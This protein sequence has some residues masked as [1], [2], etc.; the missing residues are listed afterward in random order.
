MVL[1]KFEGVNLSV[2]PSNSSETTSTI[3]SSF[4]AYFP[5][6]FGHLTLSCLF[7]QGTVS[8]TWKR[9]DIMTEYRMQTEEYECIKINIRY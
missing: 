5:V 1:L 2:S 3:F 9:G 4:G 6:F 8:Q 7:F